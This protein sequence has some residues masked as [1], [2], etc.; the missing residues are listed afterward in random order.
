MK[1]LTLL[2]VGFF[3]TGCGGAL[4]G[5]GGPGGTGMAAPPPRPE[6]VDPGLMQATDRFGI[7]LL[8]AVHAE[9]Q[10]EN[11][12]L[13]PASAQIILSLTANGA[14]GET[15][16]EMLEA[17]GYAG[18]DLDAVNQ[19]I[20]DLRGILAHPGKGVE[21]SAAN[22]IWHQKG[23]AVAPAFL[24]VAAQRYGAQVNETTFGE[25]AAAEAINR[26][27]ADQ[28]RGR[29][30]RLVDQTRPDDV[31]WLVNA[32]YF[33]GEWQK[34]FDPHRTHDRPFTLPDGRSVQVP[35]MHQTAT[36]S[37]LAEEGLVGVRLPYGEGDLALYAFMPDAWEGF[38]EGLTPERYAEW[39]AGMGLREIRLAMPKVK[40]TDQAELK[41]PLAAMGM[42]RAFTP[43]QADLGGLFTEGPE[44]YISRVIQKTFLE[45]HEEGTEAAAATGVGVTLTSAPAEQ[46]PEVVLNRPF[47]L[48]IRD[49]R[50]GV[51]LFLGAIVDPS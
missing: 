47:L 32:L 2:L 12:F 38:V 30:P 46:P 19:A 25:P 51:T 26:W 44:L 24:E 29:I 33:K 7:H 22:A 8:Q 20:R 42:E 6:A 4:P 18:M 45:I 31:M 49:D 11:L 9:R 21:L 35:F 39:I 27:V 41:E 17:L 23:M 3:L 28:T 48:A 1:L 43:G 5:A 37:Y 15:R 10:S 16:Q 34:P 40:L 36:F 13:S 14:R 50:T